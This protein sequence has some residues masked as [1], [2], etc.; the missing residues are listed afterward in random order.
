MN[1]KE[2]NKK[3][4]VGSSF[5]YQP[6]KALR[7]GKAVKT[8]ATAYDSNQDVIVEIDLHPWFANIKALIPAG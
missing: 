7:G 5:I 2:F 1:A 8:A 4:P 3:H 6:N